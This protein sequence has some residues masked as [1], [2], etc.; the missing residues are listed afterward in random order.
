MR[1]DSSVTTSDMPAEALCETLVAA[2]PGMLGF[3]SI[4]VHG[5]LDI[6]HL[7]IRS[8]VRFENCEFERLVARG[9]EFRGLR[10]TACLLRSVEL[11]HARLAADLE[12]DDCEI[13][14]LEDSG[15]ALDLSYLHADGNVVLSRSRVRSRRCAI[16]MTRARIEASVR[17]KD[18]FRADGAVRAIGVHVGGSFNCDGGAF[19]ISAETAQDVDEA[20]LVLNGATIGSSVFL[21]GAEDR[22]RA[23]GGVAMRGTEIGGQ[24]RVV[25]ASIERL[26]NQTAAFDA[27]NLRA[28]GGVVMSPDVS[29]K[30]TL[31]LRNLESGSDVEMSGIDV[32]A[33]GQRAVDLG[34][35]AV[36][37][38]VFLGTLTPV[39]DLHTVRRTKIHGGLR[40]AGAAI[41]GNLDLA[42]ATV[43]RPDALAIAGGGCRIEG[44]LKL[45]SLRA[46][47]SVRFSN[48][49][50]AG[51][52]NMLQSLVRRTD[53]VA[54]QFD[55]ASLGADVIIQQ[56]RV[57]GVT[58]L[59]GCSIAG[60][61]LVDRAILR[62]STDVALASDPAFVLPNARITGELALTNS[63]V[64][65]QIDLTGVTAAAF[66]NDLP[67]WPPFNA[68]G[69]VFDRFGES[70]QPTRKVI[71]W[72]AQQAPFDSGL[73]ET[74]AAVYR[75]AGY[76]GR[77]DDV[78]VAGRR[79]QRPQLT[80]TRR[81]L[82]TT[83]DV[84]LR[85][86][87]QSWRVLAFMV[88]LIVAIA[89][90]T[91]LEPFRSTL[92]ATSDTVAVYDPDGSVGIAAANGA[93]AASGSCASGAVRCF[94]PV[95]FAIDT[96]V[97]LV[98][99][100]QRSTW[101]ADGSTC[102]GRALEAVVVL[103]TLLG[104]SA[105]TLFALSFS[106]LVRTT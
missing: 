106:R 105:S 85:Y 44:T 12:F 57:T 86:G 100:G 83:W 94:N 45:S 77:S 40:L 5:T 20:A 66:A 32:R 76:P 43:N 95:Y 13:G 97:P 93:G 55:G 42:G 37:G 96:V 52:V 24:L 29:I 33:R 64:V 11:S 10:F 16:D 22:F 17:M 41:R 69:F 89:V 18:G 4:R 84:T 81:L 88:A 2:A 1:Q 65:G 90:T 60:R 58:S 61:L 92:K 102:T 23:D 103:A 98:E 31:I 28:S 49:A 7:E 9:T 53:R 91:S 15:P 73:Y 62:C 70:D 46:A 75:R 59:A 35:A 48:A 99:L 27:A 101:H 36:R 8:E 30:G 74:A 47:G 51:N 56:T 3:D 78:S 104:W 63:R 19:A 25:S 39:E 26:S 68:T 71:P 50:V 80:R 34:G 79:R 14:S 21:R 87:T 38:T 82:D 6:S 72:L 54:V 67:D